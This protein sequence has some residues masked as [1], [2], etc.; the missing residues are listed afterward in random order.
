MTYDD[1]VQI[2]LE[3]PEVKEAVERDNLSVNRDGKGMFWLKKGVL[4]CIKMAWEDHDRMLETYPDILYKTPHFET[5]PALH[6]NL[7]L[8]SPSLAKELVQRSW[9]DAPNKV[10]FRRQP[11]T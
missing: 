3:L 8:L 11:K 7:D 2:A 5:Y 1:F 9:N 10:K 4:L 6:A